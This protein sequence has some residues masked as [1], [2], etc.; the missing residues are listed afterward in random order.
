MSGKP[1]SLR[2]EGAQAARPFAVHFGKVRDFLKQT[3]QFMKKCARK[4][5]NNSLIGSKQPDFMVVNIFTSALPRL[6]LPF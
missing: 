5:E 1:S 2:V 3:K 4:G 6:S